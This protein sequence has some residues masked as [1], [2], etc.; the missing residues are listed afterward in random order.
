[1]TAP[2]STAVRLPRGPHQLTREEVLGSQRQRILAA[3]TQLSAEVGVESVR[4]TEVCSRAGVSK[5]AFYEQFD[6]I[7]A[8]LLAAYDQ[9]ADD[10]R[11]AIAAAVDDNGPWQTI[12]RAAVTAY[13]EVLDAS[14]DAARLFVVGAAAAPG[15]VR[16]RRRAAHHEFVQQFAAIH[17][18]ARTQDLA[19]APIPLRV[20]LA[21]V[22][23]VVGMVG[24]HLISATDEPLAELID[25]LC[26]YLVALAHA[27]TISSTESNR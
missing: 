26:T 7:A 23:G 8:A 16:D 4:V 24:E 6:G 27:G 20:H 18:L 25:D 21:G 3:L 12:I 17:D 15:P 9:I 10:V 14:P 1:M 2:T 22:E 19:L 5:S 13:L 11:T